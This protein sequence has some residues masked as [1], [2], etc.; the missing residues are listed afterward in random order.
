MTEI[1]HLATQ[2]LQQYAEKYQKRIDGFETTLIEKMLSYSWPHNVRE[3]EQSIE[4]GVIHCRG[5]TLLNDDMPENIRTYRAVQSMW[6][7]DQQSL[8]SLDELE[9]R[10]IARVLESVN[11][12]KT[13]AAQVLGLDRKTLYR[14]LARNQDETTT[15]NNI[16]ALATVMDGE[17]NQTGKNE[18]KNNVLEMRLPSSAGEYSQ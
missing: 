11:G 10:Y 3:L 9:Q 4:K 13:R 16:E 15:E 6:D 1:Y 14:K 12:N 8:M 17:G 5:N 18:G 2:F 7:D